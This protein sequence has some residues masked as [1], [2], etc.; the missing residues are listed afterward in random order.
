MKLDLEWFSTS[1]SE[2]SSSLEE[3]LEGG[4]QT[5]QGQD[6]IASGQVARFGVKELKVLDFDVVITA[7]VVSNRT[8]VVYLREREILFRL[9]DEKGFEWSSE[10]RLT[11]SFVFRELHEEIGTVLG[12]V[13]R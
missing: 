12:Q 10:R 11:N 7:V 5:H 9:R 6:E 4:Y 8:V 2:E 3:E 1:R 13:A